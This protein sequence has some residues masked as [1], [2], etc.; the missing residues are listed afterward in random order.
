MFRV[1]I[2]ILWLITIQLCNAQRS[3]FKTI[4]FKTADSIALSYQDKPLDNLPNLAY[5]LTKDLNTDIER[6]RAIYKWVCHNIAND[7]GL[8]L[9]NKYKRNRLRNDSLKY[10][11]WQTKFR[12]KLFKILRKRKRTICTGYAYLIKALAQF[13]NIKCVIIQGYGRV[14]TT[15]IN[16]TSLPNHSWNAVHINNKWYLCD[17]TW[18]AGIPDTETGKFTFTYNDSYFL[19]A[20]KL[21]ALNHYPIDNNWWLLDDANIPTFNAFLEAPIF[22]G[23][24]FKY[25]NDHLLPKT[26]EHTLT[27]QQHVK[28]KY[29]LKSDLEKDQIQFVIDNGKRQWTTAPDTIRFI[30]DHVILEHQFKKPGWYDVHLYCNDEIIATYVFKVKT[31]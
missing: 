30:N 27:T 8:Y 14:S 29:Q 19:T 24:T 18:A 12:K 4:N 15:E 6:F 10:E 20:P 23:S 21:F 25:L 3:D 5:K 2:A 31:L 9:N 1:G 11:L 22:Y 26:L 16:D 7:Y 13:A 17:P 28:F